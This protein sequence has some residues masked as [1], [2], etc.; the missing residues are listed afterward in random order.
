MEVFIVIERAT[1]QRGIAL[2]FLIAAVALFYALSA[3]GNEPVPA[4]GQ[5]VFS[6]QYMPQ[7]E[8]PDPSPAPGSQAQ[9]EPEPAA[10]EEEEEAVPVWAAPA[11]ARDG[12]AS[13]FDRFR[14]ARLQE[15]ARR[16]ESLERLLAEQA[17][18]GAARQR[19]QEELVA[20]IGAAELEERAEGLL[21]ARGFYD[22]VVVI[23]GRSAEVIVP[24]QL[25]RDQAAQVGSVVARVAGLSLDH[26]V[27]V[28]GAP[29]D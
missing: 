29:V 23:T 3:P 21:I 19:A 10:V 12:R 1:W 22:A 17:L 28:D 27:I 15:R 25:T 14:I 4:G 26:V 11:A 8:R 13:A 24:E 2:L 16:I 6:H 5:L 7:S 9:S 18:D 20:L